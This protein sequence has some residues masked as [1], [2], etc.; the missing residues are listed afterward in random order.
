MR[1]RIFGITPS[2][3][4]LAVL[5]LLVLPLAAGAD[6]GKGE[7]HHGKHMDRMAEKLELTDAQREE[8]KALHEEHHPR[9]QELQEAMRE[10]HEALREA[11]KGGFDEAAASAAAR[12]LGDLVA[13][14]AL[15]RAR[16]HAQLHDMLTEEQRAKLAE[17]HEGKHGKGHHGEHG[18]KSRSEEKAVN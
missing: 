13:E 2:L 6:A 1:T 7:G 12:R 5:A 9:M 4:A 17:F 8:W 10:Q 14:S 15:E 16:M 18:K 3:A 11:A